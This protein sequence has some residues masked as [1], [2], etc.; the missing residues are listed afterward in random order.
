MLNSSHSAC[1]HSCRY[2]N[3][4]YQG[5]NR[6]NLF[7]IIQLGR[8]SPPPFVPACSLQT[9]GLRRPLAV[10]LPFDPMRA[11]TNLPEPTAERPEE[12]DELALPAPDE[13]VQDVEIR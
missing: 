11:A 2:T 3:Q 6:S 12:Y 9:A 1:N 7:I 10:D 13:D 5:N 8:Y 4:R